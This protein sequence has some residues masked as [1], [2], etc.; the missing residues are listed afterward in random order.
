M[1]RLGAFVRSVIPADPTQLIFLVGVV[2]LFVSSRVP[3]W[4]SELLKSSGLL[5]QTAEGNYEP[6]RLR[7]IIILS[8]LPILFGGLAGYF[9]CFWSSKKI[10]PRILTVMSLPSILGL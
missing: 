10:G 8:M 4:P 2:L 1:R 9:F 6:P 3:W 5:G 7:T